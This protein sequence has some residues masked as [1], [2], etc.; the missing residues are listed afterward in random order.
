M[1]TTL[2]AQAIPL[3]SLFL[4]ITASTTTVK[5]QIIQHPALY[6]A[7]EFYN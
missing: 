6:K 7:K 1:R 3:I 4:L 2:K 5:G